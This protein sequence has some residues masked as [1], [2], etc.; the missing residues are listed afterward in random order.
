MTVQSWEQNHLSSAYVRPN[1][2]QTGRRAVK[3]RSSMQI[4]NIKGRPRRKLRGMNNSW[5]GGARAWKEVHQPDDKCAKML[6]EMKNLQPLVA[7]STSSS[8]MSQWLRVF[9]DQRWYQTNLFWSSDTDTHLQTCEPMWTT[10]LGTSKGQMPTL[11][12]K[13]RDFLVQNPWEFTIKWSSF[14]R[15]YM[16]HN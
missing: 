15:A 9:R 5:P 13:R 2:K 8:S 12:S 3:C 1:P 16:T 7:Q 14:W 6:L 11:A 4:N 10:R